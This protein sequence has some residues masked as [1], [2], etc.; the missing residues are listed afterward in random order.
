MRSI[1]AL[2]HLPL[3]LV[4]VQTVLDLR[5]AF[6]F[7]DKRVAGHVDVFLN[8]YFIK[9][10]VEEG[11]MFPPRFWNVCGKHI[12]T[13]NSAESSHNFLNKHV[14]GVLTRWRFISIIRHRWM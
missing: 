12:R 11:C 9:H 13:N 2:P 10:Y 6:K 3:E 1:M 7:Q 14:H 4:T 5:N 8:D